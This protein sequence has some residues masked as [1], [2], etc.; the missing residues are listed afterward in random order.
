MWR[1]SW[2]ASD[3]LRAYKPSSRCL[4]TQLPN[5]S[6][7]RCRAG[8]S[9]VWRWPRGTRR[10]TS[11]APLRTRPTWP[12]TCPRCRGT[13]W[14][15]VKTSPDSGLKLN[16]KISKKSLQEKYQTKLVCPKITGPKVCFRTVVPNTRPARFFC[17]AREHLKN[18][19][20]YKVWLYFV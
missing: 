16:E 9:C 7:R 2:T 11:S 20:K 15:R 1:H 6:D 4:L 3:D 14:R 8:G 5:G 12:P 19:Q 10:R 18:W 13:S 17:A